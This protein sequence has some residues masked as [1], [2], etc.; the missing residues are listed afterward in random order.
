MSIEE[1]VAFFADEPA[2]GKKIAVRNDLGPG[3]LTLGQS[4][5]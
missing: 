2:V 5:R 4:A 1:G 3:D